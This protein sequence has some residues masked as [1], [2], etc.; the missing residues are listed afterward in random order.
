MELN[1]DSRLLTGVRHIISPNCDERPEN[2]EAEVIIIHAISLPPGC[3]GGRYI[4]ALFCNR[5]DCDGHPYF[6][7]LQGLR[8]SSHF[9]IDRD[10][11]IVQFVPT[12]KR[13]W[14][15]GVSYCLGRARVN[16]FSIGI[17]L[18]GCDDDEF[19]EVQYQSLN[20]LIELLMREYPAINRRRIFGHCE[21]A[22]DRKTD[23]GP[24]FDWSR[25]R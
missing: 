19:E 23:P 10:G 11:C 20:A 7:R 25:I 22:P 13:A 5:L 9:L 6:N 18:E 4:E 21:I 14:H 12:D 16:D 24:N 1:R 2:V 3:Y 8:V 17:E 15:A